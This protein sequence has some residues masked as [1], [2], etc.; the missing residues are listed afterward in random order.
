MVN[1]G[2][3]LDCEPQGSH[4]S[5]KRV[6]RFSEELKEGEKAHFVLSL[7]WLKSNGEKKNPS[8]QGLALFTDKRILT[9]LRPITG[10]NQLSEY[11]Y[12]TVTN[13][14][15]KT[16]LTSKKVVLTTKFDD[17]TLKVTNP[18]KSECKDAVQ[19]VKNI[20][21]GKDHSEEIS[22]KSKSFGDHSP[23][24]DYVTEKRVAK[25]EEILDN[26]ENV[27][28]LT[29]GSTVDVEGSQA[30]GSLFGDD[31]SRKSGTK[32]YVR[33]AYTQKR[34]VIKIPQWMGSDE[35]TIPYRNITSVDLDTGMVNK[36]VTLQTPGQT[37]HIEAHEPGKD[38]VREVTKFVR[39]KIK[40][41]QSSSDNST[42]KSEDDPLDQLDKLKDLHEKGAITDEEFEE[43]KEGLLDKI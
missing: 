39:N 4:I 26:D 40:E 33:A 32:G 37:Y 23:V 21:D 7:A 5:E 36:R 22:D 38:E 20:L 12:S 9:L 25:V 19:F 18:R 41:S 29:R 3:S 43:K 31:R 28:Y 2:N 8:R 1:I 27:H 17:I 14:E 34:V 6:K 15:L 11:N 30:G 35:R 13:A 16:G 24:G 42:Q 10:S